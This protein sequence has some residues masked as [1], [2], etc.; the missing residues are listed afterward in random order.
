MNHIFIRQ[1]G[2]CRRNADTV[3]RAKSCAVSRHPLLIIFHVRAYSIFL[4]VKLHI[5]V[6]LRNHI[7]MTLQNNTRMVFITRISRLANNHIADLVHNSLQTKTT[8][9]I[10]QKLR[11][12]F[13]L[14]RWARNL[15]KAVEILPHT[16]RF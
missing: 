7:H 14:A 16:L 8:T 12:L 1:N 9:V 13:L 6:L 2:H 11:N 10:G 4:K 15:C 5:R 3:I